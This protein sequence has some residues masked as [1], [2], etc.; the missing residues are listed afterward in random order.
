[1]PVDVEV[2]VDVLQ[3]E[4]FVNVATTALAAPN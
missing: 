3:E 1:V 2:E 4:E